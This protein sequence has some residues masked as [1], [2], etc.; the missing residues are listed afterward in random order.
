M[1]LLICTQAV[2][3]KDP[4][5]GFF[6]RWIAEFAKHCEQVTVICLRKGAYELPQNVR[7]FTLNKKS[8][9]G[10]AY[11]LLRGAY[12][13]RKN[14]DAV[15]VHMNPEYVL[16]AGLLWRLLGKRVG[17]W[18]AHGHADFKLRLATPFANRVLTSTAEGMRIKM[19][20]R[21]VLHQGIDTDFFAP[22]PTVA[23]EDWWLS[24]GRLSPSKHHD[25]AIR[26]AHAAHKGL[27]IVGSGPERERLE[28]LAHELGAKVVFL[29]P[30]DHMQLRDVYRRAALLVH[31]GT[32]GSLDKVLLEAVA[33]GVPL[34]T[35]SKAFGYLE[36]EGPAYVRDNHSLQELIP[37]I[38]KVLQ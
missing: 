11:S 5:L 6:V 35:T 17:L 31:T 25:E 34:H 22:D 32:T 10:R 28:R 30:L 24:V 15:F 37:A 26:M 7:V 20:K 36:K 23:R 14:Y 27:R 19:A 38:L 3:S 29:G 13:F 4:V 2:D 1:K 8:K 21:V 33:S 12:K 18:Y 9:I 16:V